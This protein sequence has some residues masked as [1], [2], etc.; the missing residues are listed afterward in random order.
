MH[1]NLLHVTTTP[2]ALEQ[3]DELLRGGR[4]RLERI[5]SHGHGTPPGQWYDQE[6]DEWVLVVAGRAKLLIEGE[7]T[8]RDLIAGDYLLLRRHVRHRVEGTDPNQPTIWL[9]LHGDVA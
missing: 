6:E 7:P 8:P 9:A 2:A 1:G 4:F 3:F 5:V